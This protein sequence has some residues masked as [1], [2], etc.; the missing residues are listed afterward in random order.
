MVVEPPGD[1]RRGRVFEVDDGVLVAAKLALIEERS[2]AMRQAVVLVGG[3]GGNAFT[4][5]AR[6]QGSR[7][8]SV[9]AFVVI[10]DANPQT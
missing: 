6:E 3:A 1:A 8:G 4:V 10:K 5:K 7:A 9:K 2:G